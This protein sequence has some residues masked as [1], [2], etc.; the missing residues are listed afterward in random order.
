MPNCLSLPLSVLQPLIM[1]HFGFEN[2][3]QSVLK[4]D[5]PITNAPMARWQRK[6]N[7]AASAN[8]S[9]LSPNKSATR[10][11]SLSKTP[12]KT[13]GMSLFYLYDFWFSNS[14]V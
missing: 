6:A 2:D 13:P 11:L 3:M 12:N 14:H 4:L 10:S 1:A 9:T 8:T 7:T 5:M